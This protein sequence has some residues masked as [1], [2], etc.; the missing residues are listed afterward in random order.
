MRILY[1]SPLIPAPSGNGGKRAIYNHLEDVARG[2]HQVD[3]MVVDVEESGETVSSTFAQFR[4]R[5]FPRAM[6]LG[7]SVR[8]MLAALGQWL[9]DARPRAT[10][11]VASREAVGAVS[12]VL[13]RE[14]YDLVVVDH[15]NA[16]SLLGDRR[17]QVPVLYVAHNVETEVLA[18]QRAQHS[19]FS[20]RG[21]RLS[22][23]CGKMRRFESELL[24][25]ATAVSAI[26]A[27]DCASPLLHA[28]RDKIV[29]WPEL[30][31]LKVSDWRPSGSRTLL[32]VGSASYF[33]NRD[34]ILWLITSLMPEIERLAPD[35]VLRIAGT[36]A[37][38]IAN[39]A[40]PSNVVLEGFV[41]PEHL[42]ELHRT[43]ELFVCPV[44]LGSGIKIKVLEATS[45]GLPIAATAESL[46][47]I[48][49]L[50]GAA[51]TIGRDGAFAARQITTWLSSSE[52]LLG[53]SQAATANLI[54]ARS[55]RAPL[56]DAVSAIAARNARQHREGA[57][58]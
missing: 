38:D 47:G 37:A 12:D 5:V 26:A 10:A 33:P 18:D 40:V 54:R 16:W 44:V 24:L 15:L 34:A 29:V 27:T 8:G 46:G 35:V 45:Y 19:R 36:A 14:R 25:R 21:L 20:L 30:P 49:Y 58:S 31:D 2:D 52:R 55:E 56:L 42:D 53:A 50:E 51:L 11:V 17:L 9:F 7:R 3:L 23:E 28:V 32:F 1:L 48:D 22:I 39:V 43:A 4:P 41:S 6:P 57:A 13:A